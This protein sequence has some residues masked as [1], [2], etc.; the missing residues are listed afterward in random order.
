MKSVYHL[1]ALFAY[2]LPL[3]LLLLLLLIVIYVDVGTYDE[4]IL[5]D[6]GLVC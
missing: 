2:F 3:L 5:M 6:W 4:T 1:I